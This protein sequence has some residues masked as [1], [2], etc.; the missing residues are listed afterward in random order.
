MSGTER[1]TLLKIFF[2]PVAYFFLRLYLS[3]IRIRTLHEDALVQFLQGGG[4][5]V[6]AVWHQRFLGVLGYVRKFR[7]L[8]LSIMISLS[9]DGDWIAPVVKWLGL[10]PVRGSSTRG[11]RQAL[12]AMVQ[13]L[14]QNQAA[15]HIIDGPQG[16]KAVVKAGL[17]RL[18]QLSKGVIVP[19]YISVDRAWVTNSWD[20]FLIPKPFSRVLVRFGEPIK[21]PEQ[22][23]PEVFEVLR[24]EVEKK[25][26]DGHA[27]DDLNFGWEKPL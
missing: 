5:G 22:M 8:R 15:L 17:V 26:I 2:A 14:A 9:R 6:G 23:D 19:I 25:M 11:G 18:A 7:Y 27:Q 1:I 20:R 16:P 13:D 21:V 24:L 3:M 4:K 12:A 10:R